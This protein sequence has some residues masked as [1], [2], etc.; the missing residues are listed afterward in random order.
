MRSWGLALGLAGLFLPLYWLKSSW[1]VDLTL[2]ALAMTGYAGM[3]VLLGLVS[4]GELA[5]IW[6]ALRDRQAPP[7]QP[8]RAN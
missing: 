7:A 3:L 4:F 6:R 2:G 8:F 5:L 1:S